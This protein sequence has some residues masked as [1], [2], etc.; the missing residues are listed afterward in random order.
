MMLLA[1][2]G[3]RIKKSMLEYILTDIFIIMDTWTFHLYV[4]LNLGTGSTYGSS[5]ANTWSS[6]STQFTPSG[7]VSLV[8][9][10][11]ATLQFTGVQLEIGSSATAFERRP[12]ALEFT[13]CQRYYETINLYGVIGGNISNSFNAFL[14][15]WKLQ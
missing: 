12:F 13:L 14:N 5:T 10:N 9:T 4:T 8:G 15:M 11:A 3:K 7:T 2:L 6:Q 1:N